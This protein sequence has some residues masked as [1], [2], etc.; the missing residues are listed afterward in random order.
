MK[1][2]VC[3]KFHHFHV[4][5]LENAFQFRAVGARLLEQIVDRVVTGAVVLVQINT[6]FDKEFTF[7]SI[8]RLRTMLSDLRIIPVISFLYSFICS[9]NRKTYL[10]HS[11]CLG[12]GVV[13][14][15]DEGFSVT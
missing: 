11:Q 5:S 2:F 14:L 4:V 6:F 8:L 1:N 7:F 12:E 9:K 10:S 3:L 13:H 15:L